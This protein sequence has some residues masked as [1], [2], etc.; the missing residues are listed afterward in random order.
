MND[1]YNSSTS[2]TAQAS[3][4]RVDVI[5]ATA[6]WLDADSDEKDRPDMWVPTDLAQLAAILSPAY[7]VEIIDAAANNLTR[8]QFEILLH[9]KQAR[10]YVFQLHPSTYAFDIRG[11]ISAQSLGLTTIAFG[12]Y[13]TQHRESVMQSIPAI[14]YGIY[15]EAELTLRELVDTLEAETGR[16]TESDYQN[17]TANLTALFQNAD[18]NWQPSWQIPGQLRDRLAQIRGLIWRQ[19]G[20]IRVNEQRPALQNLDLLPMPH[21]HRLPLQKYIQRLIN[22][23]VASVEI[24]RHIPQVD[25]PGHVRSQSIEHI[26]AKLWFLYDLGLEHVHMQADIFTANHTHVESL[27]KAI[28][29]EELPLR[30]T[31]HSRPEAVDRATLVLMG[32]AGCEGIYWDLKSTFEQHQQQLD[33]TYLYHQVPQALRWAQQAGIRSWGHFKLGW[34]GETSDDI[35]ATI[36]FAKR[37]PLDL[38]MFAPAQTSPI[39]FGTEAE[40]AETDIAFASSGT[41]PINEVPGQSMDVLSA[42]DVRYWR[43]RAF[44]EW[45]LRAS[46][47]TLAKGLMRWIRFKNSHGDSVPPVSLKG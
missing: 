2:K 46:P 28:I 24:N 7:T 32:R 23:P 15:G 9:Q 26:L 33:D 3:P 8:V 6:P 44:R 4:S 45:A 21:Y 14:D 11:V 31:C 1:N 43:Q 13:L 47:W 41:L 18:P 30:W 40:M 36:T 16:L 19:H 5:L 22:A 25:Q 20:Y 39:P 34:P 12:K 29:E 35:K 10:Y 38:A 37:L 17:P 27:C 42:R